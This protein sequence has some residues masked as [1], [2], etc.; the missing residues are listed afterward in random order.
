[1]ST[2]NTIEYDFKIGTEQVS[3]RD[4]IHKRTSEEVTMYTQSRPQEFRGL[5]NIRG[6]VDPSQHI[7]YFI[8]VDDLQVES[9]DEIVQVNEDTQVEVVRVVQLTER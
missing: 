2:N 7:G 1:M 9:L 3:V 8:L 5:I 4:V 6:A